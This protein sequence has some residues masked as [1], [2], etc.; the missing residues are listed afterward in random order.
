MD[1]RKNTGAQG[2]LDSIYLESVRRGAA[3]TILVMAALSLGAGYLIYS[4]VL[5]TWID[6]GRAYRLQVAQKEIENKKTEALL[7]G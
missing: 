3:L 5:S 1:R 7:A 6:S 4:Y 2:I